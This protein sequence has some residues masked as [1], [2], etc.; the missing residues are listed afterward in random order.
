M[1]YVGMQ[2]LICYQPPNLQACSQRVWKDGAPFIQEV[3]GKGKIWHV[4]IIWEKN[5]AYKENDEI[6]N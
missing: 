5:C 4:N 6:N 1:N 2:K 3:Y